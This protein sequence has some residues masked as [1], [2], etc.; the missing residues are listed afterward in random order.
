MS[1]WKVVLPKIGLAL[2]VAGTLGGV[3]AV[4]YDLIQSSRMVAQDQKPDCK[5]QRWAGS[6]RCEFERRQQ[7][8]EEE[9]RRRQE[10][11]Q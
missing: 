2:L 9:L 1:S 5:D 3:V 4:Q 8:S 6:A 11:L 10:Q 7:E